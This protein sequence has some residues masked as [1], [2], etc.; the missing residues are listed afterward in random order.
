MNQTDQAIRGPAQGNPELR[1]SLTLVHA[2]L[3]GLGIT[4][5]AGI[6]VLI[7]PV[8]AIAG[9][10]SPTSFVLAAALMSLSALSFAELATRM[11]VAAGEAA[12]VA[13]GFRNK[14]LGTVIGLLVIAIAVTTSA[15]ISLGS[16]QYIRV[17]WDSPEGITAALVVLA[18]GAIAAWGIVE[19]ITFAGL[20]TVIE[21]G[22]LLMIAALGFLF[23][24]GS[25]SRI[26]EALPAMGDIAA[27]Q[28]VMSAGMLAVFAFIG[29]EG[30][31]NIAEEIKS[32]ERTLPRALLLTLVVTT[33]VYVAVVWVALVTLGP[34]KLGAVEAPLAAVFVAL[35]G[36]PSTVMAAI[37]I[38]ATLNGIIASIV[39][40]ARVAYGLA[41]RGALP[42][43]LA[44]VNPTTRTPLVAT[45]LVT[46]AVL[47]L[48]IW[49]P[50]TGLAE[51]SS[52]LTL[53]MF[54][55]VNAALVAIKLRETT[56]PG[57][58]FLAPLWVPIAGTAATNIF[59]IADLHGP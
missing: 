12:Y 45:T 18:M 42:A 54:T 52:R 26:P 2:L 1:R 5:G 30:I 38:I 34:V 8:A 37:A 29:F 39:L 44:T 59:L 9:M 50:L 22:G 10:A 20:M 17:F 58:I 15:T 36:W 7:G 53:V 32:P 57:G 3:Y 19:S 25:L 46:A 16:A 23:A 11:P 48:A 51:L 55:F 49:A 31:V 56:P 4:I 27:W 35:T 14:L 47:L 24:P 6:Y 43:V 13:E 21:T 41:G 33:L 40:A 28:A